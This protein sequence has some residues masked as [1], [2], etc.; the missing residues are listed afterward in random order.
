LTCQALKKE[1]CC[2][3]NVVD[4]PELGQVGSQP[5]LLCPT[6]H[7][8]AAA[9]APPVLHRNTAWPCQ[10][11]R[12]RVPPPSRSPQPPS[13]PPSRPLPRPATCRRQVIQ[14]QGDQRKNVHQFLTQEGLVK[15]NLIKLH[16]F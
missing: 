7:L 10:R 16:G 11:A 8:C 9:E 2:N 15:K 13:T 1:F 3:G 12:L 6:A 4:D 14:L 5:G